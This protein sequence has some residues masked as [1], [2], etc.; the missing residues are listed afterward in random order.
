MT[1]REKNIDAMR[2]A[3]RRANPD[4]PTQAGREAWERDLYIGIGDVLL[5]SHKAGRNLAVQDSGRFL[6]L[7]QDALE[8]E[9]G[10][11]EAFEDPSLYWD[12]HDNDLAAQS[13]DLIEALADLLAP[14]QN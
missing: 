5:A 8:E 11:V 7:R 10:W 9:A 4:R 6:E 1:D 3:C 14:G 12:L 2:A 13:D